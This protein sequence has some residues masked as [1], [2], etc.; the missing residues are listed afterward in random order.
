MAPHRTQVLLPQDK[1]ADKVIQDLRLAL[2]E[3]A[4]SLYSI[5]GRHD[6]IE[7]IDKL[8][9]TN[10]ASPELEELQI[11]ARNETEGTW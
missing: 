7:L 4:T 6:S 8:L 2:I 3:F 1:I 11:K 9:A 10:R 5:E